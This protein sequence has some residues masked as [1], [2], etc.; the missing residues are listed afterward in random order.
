MIY[1]GLVDDIM[2]RMDEDGVG[3]GAADFNSRFALYAYTYEASFLKSH[4]QFYTVLNAGL[5]A[6]KDGRFKVWMPF[7]Y[8]LNNAL[9]E[10]PDVATTV[11]K[12]MAM[13]SNVDKYDGTKRIH[14][15]GYSST[16][17]DEKV[18]KHFS[19]AGGLVLKITV[20]NAKKCTITFMVWWRRV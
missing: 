12:G 20:Q 6:R 3:E 1:E 11:Y 7:I 16:T 13:P 15:S 8:Y 2:I 18:A 17:T 19:G 10:L 9:G 4:E 14:W 5:R